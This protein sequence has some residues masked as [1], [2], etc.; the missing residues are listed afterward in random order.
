MQMYGPLSRA[1]MIMTLTACAA[2]IADYGPVDLEEPV[3]R[4]CR[5][6]GG[7]HVSQ[8]SSPRYR[9]TKFGTPKLKRRKRR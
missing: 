8:Y 1:K 6:R 3:N 5:H 4:P 9:T 7:S 2:A